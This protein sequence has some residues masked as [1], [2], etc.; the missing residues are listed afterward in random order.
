MFNKICISWKRANLKKAKRGDLNL[1]KS[2]LKKSYQN[3]A[4]ILRRISL[5]MCITALFQLLTF[6]LFA[7]EK[8]SNLKLVFIAKFLK[9]IT[10][11]EAEKSS[12]K[13]HIGIIGDTP[14]KKVVSGAQYS[15]KARDKEIVI[16]KLGSLEKI[17]HLDVLFIAESEFKN[18]SNILAISEK[19]RIL[20]V[21]DTPGFAEKGVMIN[22]YKKGQKL[23]FEINKTAVE[24]AGI[25]I[26]SK[27]YKL[28]RVIE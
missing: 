24:K 11:P 18:L 17:E 7:K 22:F 16:E 6:S 27:L 4:N 26:S 28:A 10:W 13:Y 5:L 19:K 2:C 12:D 3:R 25:K 14:L 15:F 20:T 21:A 9:F 23:R 1:Q 8:D